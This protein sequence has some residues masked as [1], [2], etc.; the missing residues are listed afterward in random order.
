MILWEFG[1]TSYSSSP[2]KP[3]NKHKKPATCCPTIFFTW[4][5]LSKL[6]YSRGITFYGKL[7]YVSVMPPC[8]NASDHQN[9]CT[10]VDTFRFGISKVSLPRFH[11]WEGNRPFMYKDVSLESCSGKLREFTEMKFNILN[12][13][14]API[15]HVFAH[16]LCFQ[17][18]KNSFQM[19]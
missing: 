13:C 19:L 9:Y 17:E 5:G 2:C 18:T 16:K 8:Q 6:L 11:C 7:A 14:W 10:L 15:F 1:R 12:R 3:N 4:T